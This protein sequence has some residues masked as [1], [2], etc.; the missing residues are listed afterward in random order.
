MRMTGLPRTTYRPGKER[1]EMWVESLQLA[2]SGRDGKKKEVAPRG[3]SPKEPSEHQT[4][5]PE[6][7]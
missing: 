2:H 7:T 1:K 4:N 6:G 5:V 3:T